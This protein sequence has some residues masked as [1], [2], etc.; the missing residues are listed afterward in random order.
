MPW[1]C[2]ICKW[3]A[4]L[5]GCSNPNCGDLQT[6][7]RGTMLSKYAK[8][9]GLKDDTWKCWEKNSEFSDIQALLEICK[10]IEEIEAYLKTHTCVK[11]TEGGG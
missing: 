6:N 2:P 8:N 11:R 9:A 4:G 10:R 7:K 5:L 3:E 1:T